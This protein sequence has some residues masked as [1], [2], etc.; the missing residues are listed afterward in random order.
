MQARSM[1]KTALGATALALTTAACTP[2]SLIAGAAVAVQGFTISDAQEAEIGAKSAQSILSQT[3]LYPNDKVQAYVAAIAQKLVDNQTDRKGVTWHYHVVQTKQINAFATPGGYLFVTTGALRLM[4][5]ESMLAGVM[6]HEIAHVTKKHGIGGI[7]K[8]LLLQGLLT[9]ASPKLDTQL[10]QVAANVGANLALKH[11]DRG[12]ETEADER[13]AVYSYAASY[14]PAELGGFLELLGKATGSSGTNLLWFTSSH[15][16]VPER[17]KAIADLMARDKMETN[18][19]VGEASYRSNVLDE[20]AAQP[21]NE[22]FEL[23]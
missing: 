1:L 17:M 5:N 13:G 23:K 3:P 9:A 15:P 11:F 10:L 18:R 20:L 14:N 22:N 4:K 6:G 16:Q 19:D 21:P 7:Q 2:A 8:E 12:Q